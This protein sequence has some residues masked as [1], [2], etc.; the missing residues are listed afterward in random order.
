MSYSPLTVFWLQVGCNCLGYSKRKHCVLCLQ[1]YSKLFYLQ[2]SKHPSKGHWFLMP[3]LSDSSE[4]TLKFES[5]S[6]KNDKYALREL[7]PPLDGTKQRPHNTGLGYM[8]CKDGWSTRR[9]T[10]THVRP[11]WIW[12]V[13]DSPS[14]CPSEDNGVVQCV[15]LPAGPCH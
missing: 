5:G 11:L 2:I 15:G 13:V 7:T 8:F 9:C 1:T 10:L 4:K 14:D 12:M 3:G 6:M